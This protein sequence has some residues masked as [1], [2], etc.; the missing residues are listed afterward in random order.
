MSAAS[1]RELLAGWGRAAASAA[2]LVRPESVSDLEDLVAGER[3]TLPMVAR[4]LGRSYGD[5]AQC[6]G[7]LVARL[8]G[9][10]P[11][12]RARRP[13]GTGARR[14]RRVT[15]TSSCGCSFR[16]VF[17]LPS[18]LGRDSSR[19]AARSRATST[20]RTTTSTARISRH[21]DYLRI[22][23]PSG[24]VEC[25]PEQRAT[26][27]RPPAAAWASPASSSRQSFGCWP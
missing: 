26:C 24:P 12:S 17:S 2:T 18:R 14:G 19:S 11:R 27:S 3:G 5:A 1:R 13:R 4:G 10:E 25:S 20:A 7:G 15:S 22:A 21:L 9:P 16:R 8:H 23:T 6:A